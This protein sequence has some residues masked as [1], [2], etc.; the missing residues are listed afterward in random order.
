MGLESTARR[1]RVWLALAVTLFVSTCVQA[2]EQL[3]LGEGL[4]LEIALGRTFYLNALPRPD[5]GYFAFAERLTGR[6]E[7]APRL[8]ALNEGQ[9]L[10]LGQTSRVPLGLA[11]ESVRRQALKQLL[12]DDSYTEKGWS[13]VVMADS[14]V[15]R[16]ESLWTI[17]FFFTGEGA[18]HGPIRSF[19]R[20]EHDVLRIGDRITVPH[21][22]LKPSF[23]FEGRGPE[24]PG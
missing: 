8:R 10:V 16:P 6:V 21:A 19:N 12:P 11:R 7:D 15:G 13:H 20:L 14:P 1:V 2:S 5:E 9:S 18:R 17:A 24:A 22:L 3:K 4:W 23:V